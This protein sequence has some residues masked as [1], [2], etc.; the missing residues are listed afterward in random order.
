MKDFEPHLDHVAIAVTS[1]K[2]SLKFYQDLGCTI[3][4]QETVKEQDV[5]TQFIDTGECHVELLEPLSPEGPVGKY[6]ATR[7]PGLHHICL[8]VGDIS[9]SLKTL[10]GKGYRL[11]NETPVKGAGGCLVAFIHPKS[12]NGVLI[13][14]KQDE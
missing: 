2:E 6:I 14:L 11:I 10:K 9:A 4:R 8:K 1:I 7:G 13:E 12:T 3:G 5:R